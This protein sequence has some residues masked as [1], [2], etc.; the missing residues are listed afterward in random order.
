MTD[1]PINLV[2][3]DVLS[4]AVLREILRQSQRSF[5]IGHCF[6]KNGSGYIKKNILGFNKAA[7]GMP[8]LV[9]TDLDNE[10][11]P[12]ALINSW[13][14]QPKHP[15][16]IF[17]VAVREVEAWLLAHREAFA[18][19]LGISIDLIPDDVDRI[20]DPK[21][22]LI[23]L[24]RRSRKKSLRDAIVPAPKSTARIG[25]DYNAPLIKFVHENWRVDSARNHSSSLAKAVDAI[26]A[27][28]PIW[29]T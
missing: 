11:C 16:L 18:D 8:F 4:E 1:I 13:L 25:R 26:D 20:P 22:E 2:V 17:R 27:F 29:S 3:E 21:Q 23:N 9:L 28:E 19:F 10:E 5:S 6:Y 12:L 24:T 15:N 14:S 7:Q